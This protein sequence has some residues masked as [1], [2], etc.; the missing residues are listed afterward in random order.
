M[1]FFRSFF[2][3]KFSADL[4]LFRWIEARMPSQAYYHFS[5]RFKREAAMTE[6]IHS[7]LLFPVYD[8]ETGTGSNAQYHVIGFAAFYIDAFAAQGN[9]GTVSGHFTQVIWDGVQS[10]TAPTGPDY[11]VHSIALVN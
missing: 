10:A 7:T 8:T 2:L 6:R 3:T 11:G 9:I 4:S 1:A 5:D